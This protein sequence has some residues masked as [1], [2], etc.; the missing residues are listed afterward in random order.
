MVMQR[1][2]G[3]DILA[4]GF[5]RT[6][7]MHNQATSFEFTVGLLQQVEPIDDEVKFWNDPTFGKVIG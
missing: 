2:G 5:T 4:K 1:L 7:Q 3:F 6:N